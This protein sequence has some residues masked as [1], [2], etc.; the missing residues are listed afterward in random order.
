MKNQVKIVK[1]AGQIEVFAYPNKLRS[2]LNLF[3]S[4]LHMIAYRIN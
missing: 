1:Y 3:P 2:I 4:L